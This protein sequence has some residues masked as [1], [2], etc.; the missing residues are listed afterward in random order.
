MI[1]RELQEVTN[2][3]RASKLSV[4]AV[5]KTNYMQLGTNHKLSRIDESAAFIFRKF[6]FRTGR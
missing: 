6:K 4:D 5:S 2:W 1:N 3:F